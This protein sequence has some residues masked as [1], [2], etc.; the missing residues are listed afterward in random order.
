MPVSTVATHPDYAGFALEG[1]EGR[2]GWIEETWLDENDHPRGYAVHTVDGRRAL[3]EAHDVIASDP[4]AGELFVGARARLLEL[5]APRTVD[6]AAASWRLT[7]AVVDVVPEGQAH[8]P[9]SKA[10]MPVW[11]VAAIGLTAVAALALT[12]IG[13]DY[14]VSYLVTG[15]LPY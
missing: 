1:P 10:P 7:G 6:G 2:L 13:V 11:R 9:R 4:D 5:D 3:L 15:H 14:G 12:E 8:A